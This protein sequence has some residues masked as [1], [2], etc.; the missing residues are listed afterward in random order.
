[1][2][3]I[4][5][6]RW[7]RSTIRAKCPCANFFK[8][9]R[10]LEQN[11]SNA[12]ELPAM[13]THYK[14]K[15]I[16]S[17]SDTEDAWVHRQ[18]SNGSIKY[19]KNTR[20]RDKSNPLA[21]I[22]GRTNSQSA[23]PAPVPRKPQ[24]HGRPHTYIDGYDSRLANEDVNG[25]PKSAPSKG[26][27]GTLTPNVLTGEDSPPPNL[28]NLKQKRHQR[29]PNKPPSGNVSKP[30]SGYSKP[31]SGHSKPPSGN[32]RPQKMSDFQK[33]QMEQDQAREER[34]KKAGA[35]PT[36]EYEE[37]DDEGEQDTG[38]DAIAAQQRELMERIQQQQRELDRMRKQR[39][40][41]EEQVCDDVKLKSEK[42]VKI[43]VA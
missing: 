17:H 37:S 21:P 32:V 10:Q 9:R 28:S 34:L 22:N 1:M 11:A 15:K 38:E 19:S 26:V 24:R 12:H 35:K 20:G 29:N 40:K 27:G 30:P 16:E 8:E 42:K 31:P 18:N 7:R 41:E 13:N 33:W 3:T 5:G 2:R 23:I 4:R 14:I 39:E 43:F 36:Y 25:I 6:E